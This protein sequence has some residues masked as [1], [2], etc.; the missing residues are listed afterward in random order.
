MNTS[1]SQKT[2]CG[3]WF[4]L[5]MVNTDVTMSKGNDPLKELGAPM[6]MARARKVKEA[7]LLCLIMAQMEKE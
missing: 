6:T 2:Q 1:L 4:I 3:P 5:P 7:F